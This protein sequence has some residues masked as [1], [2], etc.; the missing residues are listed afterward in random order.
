MR[1]VWSFWSKP[2][3]EQRVGIWVNTLEHL[4]AWGLSLETA[5]QHYPET[6]LYTD[7]LGASILVDRLGLRFA[8]VSTSL[9]CLADADSGWWSMGKFHVYREQASPFIHLDNDVFL[10]KALPDELTA[11]QVF[12]QNPEEITF[13]QPYYQ[14]AMVEGALA[15]V[16]GTWLPAEWTWYRQQ[17]KQHIA[18]CC[19]ILGGKNLDFLKHYAECAIRLLEHPC[20]RQAF[21]TLSDRVEHM[22][23]VEQWFLS[24]CLAYHRANAASPFGDVAP[25]YLFDSWDDAL[26]PMRSAHLGFTHLIGTAKRD[27]AIARRLEHRVKRDYPDLYERAVALSTDVTLY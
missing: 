20:N 27:R 7:D 26:N 22:V 4:L 5:R 2:Y 25:R 6:A 23:L 13:D 18:A 9:N 12:A 19:G 17:R 21:A 3:R 15:A 11:A 8:E 10:W 14:P 16:P 1:A 24:A